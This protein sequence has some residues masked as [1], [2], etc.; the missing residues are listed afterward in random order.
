MER[1]VLDSAN[2]TFSLKF[3]LSIGFDGYD[4]VFSSLQTFLIFMVILGLSLYKK[5]MLTSK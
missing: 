3:D 2:D 5:M 4:L 1:A